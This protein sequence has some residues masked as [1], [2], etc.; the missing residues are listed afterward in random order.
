MARDKGTKRVSELQTDFNPSTITVGKMMD[1]FKALKISETFS[2]FDYI[3]ESGYSFKLVMS[4][5]IIMVVM[6]KKT[7]YA[8]LPELREHGI[9]AGKDVFYRLKNN[10]K[11]CWRLILWHIAMR[12]IQ[13]TE[14]DKLSIEKDKPHYLIFDDTTLEKTGKKI[15]KIGKVHDHVD[16]KFVLGFKALI[17]L[18]WDGKSAIPLDFS[19]HSEKGSR[20]SHPY[21]MSKKELRKQFTKK[22]VKEAETHQRIEELD[23]SKIWMVLKMFISAVSRCL[24]VDYVLVDSWFTCEALIKAVITQGSH[25]IGMYKI[26]TTKFLYKGKSMNFKQINGRIVDVKYCR[27]MKLYYKRADVMYGDIPVTLFFSRKGTQGDWKVFLTTD[28][29][30][31]FKKLVEHYQVRWTIEVFIKEAKGLLNLGGCQS[32]NFDAQI[33]DTT[34]VMITHILLSLRFRYEHYESKG[35]LFRDMNADFLRMTLDKRLMKL[36]IEVVRVVADI[37]NVDAD[38]LFKRVL[39]KPEAEDLLILFGKNVLN[40]TG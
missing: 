29:N 9:T 22:R 39:N 34:I 12:F 6:A 17:M 14:S 4:L 31:S 40:E 30:L 23:S 13:I 20:D 38:D 16:Q 19:L 24:Q 8:S 21:G 10:S 7:V 2:A 35:A 36:F 32:S 1:I 37:L 18:Y 11:I 25:L 3:K 33:A 15:E 26:A 27:T 28:T 5:L